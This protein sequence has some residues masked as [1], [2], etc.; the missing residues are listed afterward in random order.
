M[1]ISKKGIAVSPGF[2]EGNVVLINQARTIVD[3]KK[4][5]KNKIYYEINRLQKAVEDS[6]QEISELKKSSNYKLKSEHIDILDFN[7]LILEDEILASEVIQ[8]IKKE[9][10]NAEWALNSVLTEKSKNYSKVKDI[11]MQERL[12]DFCLLYTSPSP[13]DRG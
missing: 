8:K 9:L 2:A 12:A 1:S 3:K 11:Y 10:I 6:I 5:K 13:R 4:I 7:I